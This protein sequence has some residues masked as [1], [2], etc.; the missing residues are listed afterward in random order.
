MAEYTAE[1]YIDMIIAY[2]I[3]GEN[4]NAAACI[5]AQRFP[6]RE[7]H[8]ARK[9]ILRCIQR[10]RETGSVLLNRQNAGAPVHIQVNDEERILRAFEENPQ[11]SMR[12]TQTLGLLRSVVHRTLG[13]NGLHP[14]HY[15][16]VQQLLPRDEEQRIYF[17]EGFLYHFYLIFRVIKTNKYNSQ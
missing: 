1:E 17:C 12:R 3:A 11:N 13:R 4:A 6:D 5:Y 10:G 8:P 16:R 15:Q 2:A 9:T 7:R 14:Y